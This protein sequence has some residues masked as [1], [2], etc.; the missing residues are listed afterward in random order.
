MTTVAVGVA[1][2]VNLATLLALVYSSI[3]SSTKARFVSLQ[4]AS[5]GGAAH[6]FVGNGPSS[7]SPVSTTNC[8][9][10]LVALQAAWTMSMQSNLIALGDIWLVSDTAGQKV[11]CTVEVG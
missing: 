2:A 6:L 4:M 8:G 10:D 9:V 1:P 3:N 11:N 7:G 5:G